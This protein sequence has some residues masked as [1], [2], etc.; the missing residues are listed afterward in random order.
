MNWELEKENLERLINVEKVSYEEIG[1]KYGC[2]GANIKKQAKKLGIELP[3]RRKINT[4]EHFNKGVKVKDTHFYVC[5]NCG[6]PLKRTNSKFC[7]N[8]CQADYNYYQWVQQWKLGKQSGI[9]GYYGISHHL[10]RYLLE[11]Y[12]NKCCKCGWCEVNPYT[13]NIP[14]EVDHVDGDFRNNTENN[15]RLLCPNCHSLTETY[16]GANKGQGRKDRKKYS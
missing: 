15:L 13:N 7:D 14:L 1:R 16:K 12:N 5:L 10:R 6:K 3:S 2:S 11:K 4:S 9:I 8:K